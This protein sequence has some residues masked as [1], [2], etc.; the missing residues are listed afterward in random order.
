MQVVDVLPAWALDL[1][2]PP[3]TL[4]KFPAPAAAAQSYQGNQSHGALRVDA[5]EAAAMRLLERA[6]AVCTPPSQPSSSQRGE[7]AYFVPAVLC[8]KQDLRLVA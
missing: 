2:R 3:I 5:A 6:A 1:Q 8:S 7:E 4:P